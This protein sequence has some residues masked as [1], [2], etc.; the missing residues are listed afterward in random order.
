MQ[1]D[2]DM[3]EVPPVESSSLFSVCLPQNSYYF[4]NVRHIDN[5]YAVIKRGKTIQLYDHSLQ[6][7]EGSVKQI[8]VT[9]LYH[10]KVA[11]LPGRGEVILVGGA[12]DAE[13]TR[14][15]DKV[16]MIDR[17]GRVSNKKPICQPRAKF[18]VAVGELRSEANAQFRKS[19]VYIFGG[20]DKLGNALKVCEKY[21]VKADIWQNM[22]SMNVARMNAT[23]ITIGDS[24]YVFGGQ[25][26]GKSIERLNLKL[27]MQRAGDKFELLDINL[28][29]QASDIGLV[30]CLSATDILLVGGFSAEGRCVKQQLKFTAKSTGTN[31]SQDQLE[32]SIEAMEEEICKPDFFSSN[33]VVTADSAEGESVIVFG[34]QYKHIF[35]GMTFSK[36]QPI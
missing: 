1:V 32:H 12:E 14:L 7:N 2:E 34:A 13:C 35:T 23:G 25:A 28:P 8:G 4:Q 36:S 17:T 6:Q 21:N 33:N 24:L 5:S 27:N 3:I 11:I 26:G 18:G 22:P 29:V 15:S 31:G 16:Q 30:P 9:D 10:V 20:T 19:F